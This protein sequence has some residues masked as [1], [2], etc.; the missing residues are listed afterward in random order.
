M[1]N[2]VRSFYEYT[3][4]PALLM[5]VQGNVPYYYRLFIVISC[6]IAAR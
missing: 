4:N 5:A 2:D 3:N 6:L 1:A